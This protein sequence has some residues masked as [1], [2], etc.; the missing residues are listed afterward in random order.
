MW[1]QV[2]RGRAICKDD[3]L[4][5]ER[6]LQKKAQ[7]TFNFTYYLVFKTTKIL[8]ELHYLLTPDQGYKVFSEVSII[9]F[10]NALSLKCHLVRA[11]LR[12]LDREGRYKLYEGANCSSEVC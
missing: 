11:I 4:N 7:V 2:L 12:Q 9:G 8:K 6:T 3:L 1:K 10:K 5:I